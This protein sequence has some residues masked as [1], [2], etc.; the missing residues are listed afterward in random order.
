M[1]WIQTSKLRANA[2]PFVPVFSINSNIRRDDHAYLENCL[3]ADDVCRISAYDNLSH[4][5][6]IF[7]LNPCSKEFIPM[8]RVVSMPR[9]GIALSIN[10]VVYSSTEC[11]LNPSVKE[12]IPMLLPFS[13]KSGINAPKTHETYTESINQSDDCSAYSILKNLRLSNPKR[14]II[15]HLNINSIRK[16]IEMLSD[17]VKQKV[18]ILLITETKIDNSFSSALFSIPGFSSPFRLNRSIHGGGIILYVRS[19]IPCRL[20]KCTFCEEI[21]CLLIEINVSK[22]KW[23]I[24]GSYNPN[25]SSISSHL[26]T[27]SKSL[28]NYT[29]LFD[30]IILL[31]DFNSEISENSMKEFCDMYNLKSLVKEPTCFKNIDKPSCIDL[32]LTNKP[33][34]FQDTKVIETGLSDFHKLTI[35]VL[36]ISFK[37]EKPN[38]ISYRCYKNYSPFAFRTELE[39]TFSGLDLNLITNDEFVYKFMN[40]FE[41]HAPI[42]FKYVRANEG[43]FMTKQLRKAIMVRSKLRNKLNK[44]KTFEANLAYKKQ[45]NICTSILRNSKKKYYSNLNPSVI[46]DNKMFW[47]AVKPIFTEKVC[48]KDC[49]TLIE[50]GVLYDE[51]D[52]VAKTFNNFFSNVVKN[53]NLPKL[54]GIANDNVNEIDPIIKSINKYDNHPSIVRIKE[55]MSENENDYFSFEN[56]KEDDI[57][58][59]ILSLD[60]SKS[61]PKD[62]IPPNIIKENHD[63]FSYKLLIDFN[64]SITDGTFPNNLKNADVS[65]IFK[66]GDRLDK[67]NYRPISILSALSKIFERLLFEQINEYMNP[68]L[69]IHQ[70]GFRKNM[71]AQNCILL[72]LEKWK[73]CLDKKGKAGILL[74]DLSKAFDC[75]EHELLLAKLNAYGFEYYAIKL[76]HS[77]LTGRFQRVRINSNYSS[78]SEILYGVP[79]GSI[80]G[81]LLF[82]IYLSDLFLFCQDINIANYADDNSPYSCNNDIESVISQLQMDSKTLLNWLDNNRL[83]ANP[84]KFHLVL[85]ES[86]KD[87]YFIQIEEFKIYNSTC[88]KLLGIKIDNKMSFDEHV[89]SLCCKA[90]QKLHALSRVARFM[91]TKQKRVIMKA[92]IHSQFGYCPLV[93]MFCNRKLNNRINRIHERALRIVYYDKLSSFEELLL[94]DNSVSIHIRNIQILALEIYKVVNDISPE[95]MKQVFQIKK[96]L[97]YPS[98]N[99]FETRNIH[100]SSYGIESLANLGPK[101]WSLVPDDIKAIKSFNLFKKNI[102]LWKP[103]KCP[104][105]ICKTYVRGIGYID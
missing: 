66:K 37:K 95:I 24:Y 29:T 57:R 9:N 4:T 70:C 13:E 40:V 12:F 94:K 22:K 97:R 62:S 76:I 88:E 56:L 33:K 55:A 91:S 72:M 75:L 74:T 58:K 78:W 86:N 92:F 102:K 99:I 17:L 79:Q 82:N 64:I 50:D 21:E 100:T 20:L 63:I 35:S 8:Q 11:I 84:D 44:L 27:L 28:D 32:I 96:S 16:K 51:D 3:N 31:G 83:K 69:S 54:E 10:E 39:Y 41:R 89:V 23:L 52:K 1:K 71:S 103:N 36:K 45:R 77:Y 49:I 6:A 25:K 18:D 2:P 93:W 73:K 90:T 30:N 59:E 48:T 101:I 7:Q 43:P 104:C 80:L 47:K 53:L 65:P 81:P 87:S 14:I 42:K 105:N 34:S 67:S 5:A 60:K 68:K 46:A 85:S 15:G 98:R 61:T 26:S 19:D 38:I